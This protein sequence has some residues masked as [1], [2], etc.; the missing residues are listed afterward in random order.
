MNFK[1]FLDL[2]DILLGENGCPWDRE[3]TH[4]SLRQYLLE[5]CYEVIDA[6]NKDEP[7]ALCEELGDVL[8]QVVFH[9]KLAEKADKFKIEDVIQHVSD[10]LISRHTHVFGADS[11]KKGEDV[12]KIWEA[13]KEKERPRSVR[14]A[15]NDVPKALPAL[16]R[17][18]KVIKRSKRELSAKEDIIADINARLAQP[19][20]DGDGLG[21]VLMS[22]VELANVLGVNAELSLANCVEE[23]INS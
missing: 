1:Q 7:S 23:F 20:I 6:I 22:L 2:M 5:E 12:I 15:M 18:S 11:A 13:N 14:D 3:Q 16:V 8:L 19:V 21:G 10:K 9:A 4:E 17:A